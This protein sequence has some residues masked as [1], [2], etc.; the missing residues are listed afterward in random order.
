[1][2]DW[3]THVFTSTYTADVSGVCSV[4]Y[5]LGGMTVL[6]D[7]SGCNSTYTTHD[8]PRWYDT[9]SLMFVSGLDEMAAVMGD[10]SVVI[11]DVVKAAADLKPRF[12]T[13]CGAS[14][15]HIIAFDYRGVAHLIEEK[16]GIPVLPVPTD[17][18]KSYISGVGLA[19]REWI[20]RFADPKVPVKAHSMNL[21]GVTPIDFADQA[22]VEVLKKSVTPE[23]YVVN[24][25]FAMGD[26]FEKEA[27][28]YAGAV[29][30]LPT[31]A[32]R[33]AARF[34][35]GIRKVPYVEGVPIGSYMSQQIQQAIQDS[36]ADGKNRTAYD[37]LDT[38]GNM[39]VIGE[40]IYARSMATAVNHTAYAKEHQLKASAIW[41]DVN[42]GLNEDDL[43]KRVNAAQII[44]GDPLFRNIIHNKET[45]MIE[46]PHEGYSGRIYHN[47]VPQFANCEFDI[48]ERLRERK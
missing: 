30:V 12:I 13:L 24:A 48:E 44:I 17:G 10:D 31:S 37:D 36:E 28:V 27:E 4:L 32:G 25:C 23:G 19:S 5:E 2:S 38:D 1:M 34:M 46:I 47:N 43:I 3:H 15:P 40:E 11:N 14:I 45:S 7:P 18:L 22:H 20:R 33:M 42:E 29:N 41:P 21:L 26:T 16:T 39:L 8:E 6:H 35:Q 9:K